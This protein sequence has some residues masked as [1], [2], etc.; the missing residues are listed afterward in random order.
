MGDAMQLSKL[1]ADDNEDLKINCGKTRRQ[2]LSSPYKISVGSAA[3][4][5]QF[6]WAAALTLINQEHYNYCGGSII[7]KRHIITAAHCVMKYG[8]HQLPCTLATNLDDITQIAVRYGGVCLRRD[9]PPCDG[10]LCMTA[11]IRKIAI[12]KRFLDGGC[13]DGHDFAVVEMESDLMALS[14]YHLS[15]LTY[16]SDS[17]PAPPPPLLLLLQT[18]TTIGDSGAGLQGFLGQR[19]F[20][21]GIHSF[22]PKICH[23]GSPFTVTDTRPYAQLICHITG[24]CYH[25]SSF[26]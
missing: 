10:Q 5:G 26:T 17:A 25:L 7:S 23:N 11:R 8:S 1:D 24:I 15:N 18:K 3:K 9:S 21:L 6:P 13:L 16:E 22:G 12:H 20:L 2:W 4:L 14:P 19:V